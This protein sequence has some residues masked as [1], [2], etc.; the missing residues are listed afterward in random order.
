M[1][2]KHCF[3]YCTCFFNLCFFPESIYK[4]KSKGCSVI[5]ST[6]YARV[7]QRRQRV[8]KV[9]LSPVQDSGGAGARGC[10]SSEPTSTAH[11]RHPACP[12]QHLPSTLHLQKLQ[13]ER[14]K[15]PTTRSRATIHVNPCDGWAGKGFVRGVPHWWQCCSPRFVKGW[16]L[17]KQ[18]FS[19][20][21][22]LCLHLLNKRYWATPFLMLGDI[23]M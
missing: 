21:F 22:L 7:P 11:S 6:S 18:D 2:T 5:T 9:P 16:L 8:W 23:Q 12:A 10:C 13:W 15:N 14:P 20:L 3:F 4:N 17:Q 1:T 19:N